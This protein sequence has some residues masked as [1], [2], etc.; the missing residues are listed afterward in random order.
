[1]VRDGPGTDDAVRAV[2]TVRIDAEPNGF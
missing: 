1:M 2:R